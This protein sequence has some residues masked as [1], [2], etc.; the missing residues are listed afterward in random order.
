MSQTPWKVGDGSALSPFKSASVLMLRDSP[1]G[2]EIFLLRRHPLSGSW[3]GA[4][5]FPGGKLDAQDVAW[6]DRLD[7][8]AHALQCALREA[9][10]AETEAAALYVAAIR[11]VFEEAHVLF[12]ASGSERDSCRLDAM[13]AGYSFAQVMDTLDKPL[14]ASQLVPWSRWITPTASF[15][16]HKHFDVRFFIATVPAGQEPVHDEH[17]TTH[18]VWSTPLQALREYWD[19]AIELAPPQLMILIQ[20]CQYRNVEDVLADAR[21][22]GPVHV[23]PE[24]VTED[25]VRVVCFPGDRRHPVPERLLAGPTR[26]YWR[27][28]RYEASGGFDGF[29]A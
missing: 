24:I 22:R 9:S 18:S 11:E 12:V 4:Y 17:E 27:G 13:R 25:G 7:Q 6:L 10:L 29:F 1:R 3:A 14:A 26:M 16:V 28:T 15:R 2:I 19:D 5:V 8:P 23:K 20:L 21:S